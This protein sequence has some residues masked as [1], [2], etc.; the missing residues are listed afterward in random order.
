MAMLLKGLQNIM[1][2]KHSR[3]AILRNV[4]R[5]QWPSVWLYATAVFFTC[6]LLLYLF[7]IPGFDIRYPLSYQKDALMSGVIIKTVIETGW[8]LQNTLLGAPGTYNLADFPSADCANFFILKVLT[9]FSQHYGAILNG[10]YFLTFPITAVFSLFVFQRCGLNRAYA[11]S[12]A[13]LFTFLPYHFLRGEY[14]LFLSAYYVVPLYV[15]LMLSVFQNKVLALRDSADKFSIKNSVT[16]SLICIFVASSGIYYA[17]FGAYFILIAGVMT[18]FATLNRQP[19]MKALLLVALIAVTI[20]V[21]V[22]PSIIAK[23]ALGVNTEA[24]NRSAVD[25]ETYGLR[26]TQMVFPVDEHHLPG[27]RKSKAHYNR[28]APLINENRAATLGMIASLGFFALLFILLLRRDFYSNEILYLFSRLNVFGLL[29]GTMGGLG[30]VFAYRFSPMIRSYNRISIFIAFFALCAFFMVLQMIL[31][32]ENKLQ[33]VFALLVL[34]V[35]LYDQTPVIPYLFDYNQEKSQFISDG[36]FVAKI[37]KSLPAGSQIFQ[38]PFMSFPESMPINNMFD[39]DPFRGF[40]HSDNL[41]WSYGAIKGRSVSAW[42]ERVSQ[43]SVAAMLKELHRTGFAGIYIDRNGFVDH[44]KAVE[45][46]LQKQLH[47]RPMVSE[48]QRFVFFNITRYFKE[49]D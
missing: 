18:A 49:L 41:K 34:L 17:F 37:E 12:A 29:L 5:I 38:L 43:M 14:H 10:F 1:S 36:N 6:F 16:L 47:A 48:D 33:W 31:K 3:Q 8:F 26:I 45:A 25:A 9:L 39:H 32:K 13:L 35:G 20:V 22:S 40:L 2:S 24:A 7:Y 11:F 28:I 44:A 19:V 21:N 30:A 15:L 23:H 46:E 27:F 4:D 42:Q